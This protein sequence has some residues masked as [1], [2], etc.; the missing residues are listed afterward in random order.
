MFLK[1]GRLFKTASQ[2]HVFYMKY[3]T[4]HVYFAPQKTE[5]Y[6]YIFG[7]LVFDFIKRKQSKSSDVCFLIG[8]DFIYRFNKKLKQNELDREIV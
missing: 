7:K 5:L 3:Y 1:H 2:T 8:G 6:I 4:T